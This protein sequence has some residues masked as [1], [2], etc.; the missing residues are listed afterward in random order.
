[1]RE[2]CR[3]FERKCAKIDQRM[4]ELEHERNSRLASP[5]APASPRTA[6]STQA[7]TEL[8]GPG[9]IRSQLNFNYQELQNP[10]PPANLKYSSSSPES[11]RSHYKSEKISVRPFL[12]KFADRHL[13]VP[14]EASEFDSEI[15]NHEKVVAT[16]PMETRS[17]ASLYSYARHGSPPLLSPRNAPAA[18]RKPP[19]ART[20]SR[21]KLERADSSISKRQQQAPDNSQSSLDLLYGTKEA[22]TKYGDFHRNSAKL[23]T[24]GGSPPAV[25]IPVSDTAT[26]QRVSTGSPGVEQ[27][28]S[29]TLTLTSAEAPTVC[30]PRGGGGGAG[31]PGRIET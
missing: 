29:M 21:G 5:K 1:M 22:S 10:P 9:S 16:Q 2:Q 6:A 17:N 14:S 11:P 12:Q 20:G 15:V 13:R 25:I 7:P 24:G 18:H 26:F 19:L 8:P 3:L 27:L 23:V 30:S 31:I 4:T 28:D